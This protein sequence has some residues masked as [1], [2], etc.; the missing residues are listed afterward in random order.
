MAGSTSCSSWFSF[1]LRPALLS[2]VAPRRFGVLLE[3]VWSLCLM[4]YHGLMFGSMTL[5]WK[6]CAMI[7]PCFDFD[8]GIAEREG[9]FELQHHWIKTFGR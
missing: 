8:V 4:V 2:F 3:S 1:A 7:S 6:L 5:M 9:S